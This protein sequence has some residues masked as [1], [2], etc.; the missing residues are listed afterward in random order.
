MPIFAGDGTELAERTTE[1]LK[2]PEEY[3]VILLNDNYTTRE[4]VVEIL[5]LIFQK[6]FEDATRLMLDVHR[7]GKGTAGIYTYDIAVTKA[8]QVHE[9]AKKYEF[10][11]RC[12]VEEA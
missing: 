4:F 9:T 1:K 11:L 6:S 2:E 12:I 3:R 7:R 5:M 8:Q 10:P